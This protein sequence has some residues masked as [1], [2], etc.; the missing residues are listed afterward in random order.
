MKIELVQTIILAELSN[1][2]DEAGERCGQF[3]SSA[4]IGFGNEPDIQLTSGRFVSG[5]RSA[6]D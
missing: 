5:Q 4:L 2:S 3:R 1:T 6:S